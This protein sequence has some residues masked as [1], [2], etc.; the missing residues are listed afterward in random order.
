MDSRCAP[1]Q[2]NRNSEFVVDGNSNEHLHSDVDRSFAEGLPS[3]T[4][5][6]MGINPPQFAGK[7]IT[8]VTMFHKRYVR[9]GGRSRIVCLPLDDDVDEDAG[10]FEGMEGDSLGKYEILQ[11]LGEGTFGRVLECKLKD[12]SDEGSDDGTVAIKVVRKSNVTERRL[13]L[14]LIFLQI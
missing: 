2:E 1:V 9:P 14:R 3:Y 10:N 4:E 11:E 12:A 13:K 5:S 6:D 7:N 8:L